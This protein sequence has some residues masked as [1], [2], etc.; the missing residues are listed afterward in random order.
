MC[1]P[2]P[3]TTVSGLTDPAACRCDPQ[4]KG[5]LGLLADL[6]TKEIENLNQLEETTLNSD[7]SQGESGQTLYQTAQLELCVD[8][9]QTDLCR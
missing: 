4:T 9:A 3:S 2:P 6:I 7:L 8:W 5:I 1:P